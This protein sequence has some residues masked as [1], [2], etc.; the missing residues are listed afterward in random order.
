MCELHRLY[1]Y[2][3]QQTALVLQFFMHPELHRLYDYRPQQ[4]VL[5]VEFVMH[6]ELHRL[7]VYRP[8]QTALKDV[9][10]YEAHS[11]VNRYNDVL[12]SP[13]DSSPSRTLR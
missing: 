5:V 9:L 1:E 11:H 4:T 3:P 13:P 10:N 12:V 7:Y 6:P 8:Q 2:R